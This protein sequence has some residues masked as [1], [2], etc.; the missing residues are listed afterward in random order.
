M[1]RKVLWLGLSFLLVAALVLASCAEAVPGE[2]EEEEEEEEEEEIPTLSIGET[3]QSPEVVV[4][5]SEAI[6]TDSYDYYDEALES[7]VT[8]KASSGKF[9]LIFTAE[10]EN[11][12]GVAGINGEDGEVAPR[13]VEGFRR[14]QVVDS[15]GKMGTSVRYLGEN[16]LVSVLGLYPG[17]K[18]E[19]KMAFEIREE[20]SGLK[21]VY[22]TKIVYPAGEMVKFP[23]EKLVEW[24]IE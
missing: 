20:A 1:K 8:R 21:I 4:T 11:P 23:T 24:E 16:P 6:I 18:I 7:M 12:A 14:F 9:F 15:E 22:S 19:G 3:F 10:I 17:E 5:V 13:E 2:Q